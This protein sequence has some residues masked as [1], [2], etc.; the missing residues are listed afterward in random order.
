MRSDVPV[1][2]FPCGGMDLG[3]LT[4]FATHIS[5]QR[6]HTC[7]IGLEDQF[8]DYDDR[9]ISRL[10]AKKYQTYHN[11]V[12]IGQKDLEANFE[13]FIDAIDHPSLDGLNSYFV[14]KA[15]GGQLKVILSGLGSDEFFG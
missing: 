3:I 13:D 6:L 11:E 4:A 14:S 9:H 8:Q 2:V 1:G 7:T 5:G 12:V 10:I 15:V